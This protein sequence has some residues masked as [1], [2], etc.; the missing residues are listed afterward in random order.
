MLRR[1]R[2]VPTSA[3][4]VCRGLRLSRCAVP[5]SRSARR[6]AQS[7]VGVWSSVREGEQAKMGLLEKI[8]QVDTKGKVDGAG[9]L[10]AY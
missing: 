5:L 1:R 7:A 8:L 6:L 4:R 3:A 9:I 10:N 2:A